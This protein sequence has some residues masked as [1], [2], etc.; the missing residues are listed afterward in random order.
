MGDMKTS[1]TPG[2]PPHPT[3]DCVIEL[4]ARE[5]LGHSLPN[6]CMKDATS[7][8]LSFLPQ[9]M[10]IPV[11]ASRGCCTLDGKMYAKHSAHAKRLITAQ[12]CHCYW[13]AGVR[14]SQK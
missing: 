14:G 6:M 8:R 9:K 4:L 12:C 7:L 5:P 2:K 11:L 1:G 13:Q 3:T 10:E